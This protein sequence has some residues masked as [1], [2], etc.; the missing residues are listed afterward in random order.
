MKL[1][2]TIAATW[3]C[4]APGSPR[5]VRWF[6]HELDPDLGC[7]PAACGASAWSSSCSP[8]PRG[9]DGVVAG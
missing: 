8:S 2:S 7:H 3:S 9:V 5:Q 4:N 1:L 6:L